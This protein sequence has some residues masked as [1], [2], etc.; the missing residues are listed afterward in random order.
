MAEAGLTHETR[1]EQLSHKRIIPS[2]LFSP[3][4]DTACARTVVYQ[5]DG[6]FS[7]QSEILTGMLLSDSGRIFPKRDIQHESADCF[8][9]TSVGEW[10]LSAAHLQMANWTGKTAFRP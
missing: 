9:W 4:S 7:Q 3:A 1:D 8:Q 2:G 5:I 10:L 6:D